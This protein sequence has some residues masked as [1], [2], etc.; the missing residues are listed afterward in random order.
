ML[1][2]LK[3]AWKSWTVWFNAVVMPLVLFIPD[4]IAYF[5]QLK[6]YLP[7]RF[8]AYCMAAMLVGNLLL[9]FKTST[10]LKDK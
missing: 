10:P 8:Y 9:R 3:N 6:P 4:A 1:D 5:P 2:N 7:E